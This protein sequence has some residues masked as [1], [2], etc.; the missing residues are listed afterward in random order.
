MDM[1]MKE[2][3][4]KTKEEG[5]VREVWKSSMKLAKTGNMKTTF[6]SCVK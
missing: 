6:A 4:Q 3:G 2:L 5:A 1:E